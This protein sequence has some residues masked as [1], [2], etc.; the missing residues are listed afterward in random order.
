MRT[1][2]FI[3]LSSFS[4][5]SYAQ[6]KTSARPLP[7]V[8]VKT[9]TGETISTGTFANNGKPIIIDFWATWCKPCIEEL[10]AIHEL[11]P[12]WQKESGVKVIVIS[13]DDART[14]QRVAPFVNGRGWNYESYIDP[15]GDFKRAMNVNV[16]PQTF[17]LNGNN[18]IV[19]QH[20][21]YAEGNEEEIHEAVMHAA[22]TK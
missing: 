3:L 14:M 4:I 20:V 7:K 15:N 11:Y 18:E 22:A 12:D 19:W 6:E 5:A 21:G 10:N 2:V 8:D 1:L 9:M 17:V 16:P 13:L